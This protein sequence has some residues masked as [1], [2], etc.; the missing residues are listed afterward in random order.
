MRVRIRMSG[1][2]LLLVLVQVDQGRATLVVV[3]VVAAVTAAT[4]SAGFA[5][6]L[7]KGDR[8]QP[9]RTRDERVAG[10]VPIRIV[11]PADDVKEVTLAEGQFLGV[12]GVGVVVVEGLDDLEEI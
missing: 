6:D 4:V 10:F 1:G 5:N 9:P 3:V 11:L 12:L 7:E 8:H 2:R